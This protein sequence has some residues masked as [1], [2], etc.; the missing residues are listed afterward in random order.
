M[1]VIT[2]FLLL[3]GV[4][5]RFPFAPNNVFRG[6]ATGMPSYTPRASN[7]LVRAGFLRKEPIPLG[8]S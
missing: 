7:R 5:C 3:A 8:P 1:S 4:G 6:Y 2:S